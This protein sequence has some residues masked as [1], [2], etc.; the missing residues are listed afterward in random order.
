MC[1]KRVAEAT[2]DRSSHDGIVMLVR[3]S[4]AE[5][6][7]TKNIRLD[8]LVLARYTATGPRR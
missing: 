5:F 2:A 3:D 1:G 4:D 8:N 6:I 7:W